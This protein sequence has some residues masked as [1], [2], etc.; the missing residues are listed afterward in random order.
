MRDEIERYET[1]GM[2]S[3]DRGKRCVKKC[4]GVRLEIGGK[5]R[6]TIKADDVC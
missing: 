2:A 5:C 6:L 3:R 4:I 1:G